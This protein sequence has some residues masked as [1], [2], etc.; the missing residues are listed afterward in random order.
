MNGSDFYERETALVEFGAFR[1]EI[2]SRQGHQH[3]LLTVQIA[4][5]GAIFS[6]ALSAAN[7]STVLLV[8]PVATYMVT[9]RYVAHSFAN[10]SIGRYIRT[11][12][13]V[14]LPGGLG[15]EE[16]LDQQ[17]AA[18]RRFGGLDPLLISFPGVSVLAI[19]SVLPHLTGLE[20]S[21][22]SALLWAGWVL[23]IVLTAVSGRLVWRIRDDSFLRIMRRGHDGQSGGT[24]RRAL[25]DGRAPLQ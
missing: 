19:V 3:A 9:G 11:Q 4:V 8:V 16:W 25:L 22:T 21:L 18:V 15:W 20:A 23:G 17:R 1:N 12:L 24:T 13:S 7:R 14:K 6:F 2:L 10:R 5:A